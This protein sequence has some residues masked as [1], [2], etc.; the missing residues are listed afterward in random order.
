MDLSNW[1]RPCILMKSMKI[2]CNA[3]ESNE[4]KKTAATSYLMWMLE[5]L[6]QMLSM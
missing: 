5:R 6:K 4:D 2:K 1:E 3:A